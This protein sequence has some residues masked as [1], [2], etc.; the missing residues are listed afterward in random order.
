MAAPILGFTACDTST[1]PPPTK[2]GSQVIQDIDIVYGNV[3]SIQ[4]AYIRSLQ[5]SSGAIKDNEQS[6]SK[7]T[8]YFANLSAMA[9]LKNPTQQNQD[10]VKKYIVWYLKKLNASTNPHLGDAPEIEGSIYD[11]YAPSEKTEGTYDSV[12]SYAATFLEVLKLYAMVSEEN[13][14]WLKKYASKFT[15]VANAMLKTI[16]TD[17]NRIPGVTSVDEDDFLSVASFVYDV[18]YLMDNCELN[19]GLHAAQWLKEK[20]IIE[21]AADLNLILSKNT[22]SIKNLYKTD[23]FDYWKVKAPIT[24]M[25]WSKFYPNATAQLY[26][27][28]FGIVAPESEMA[29]KVYTLFNKH[30]PGWSRGEYYAEYP[31]AF[32][33]Y[34]A[35]TINDKVRVE[36]YMKHINS[37]N[38]KGQQMTRWFSAEAAFVILAIDR[39]QHPIATEE[40]QPMN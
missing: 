20:Q 16:D 32:I 10:V 39:M 23:Y 37:F 40:Y 22:E 6:N 2:D 28:T 9:L 1:A 11:Y 3:S 21:S 4:Q 19:M 18:K 25:D 31:W 38:I 29:N 36:T 17:T 30:Y 12:D 8:P 14:T 15:L 5:L 26:P 24:M 33:S 13:A 34:A 7:I 27:H 35:A